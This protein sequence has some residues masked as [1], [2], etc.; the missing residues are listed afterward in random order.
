MSVQGDSAV[1]CDI[2]LQK[3][4]LNTSL[5]GGSAILTFGLWSSKVHQASQDTSGLGTFSIT[6]MQGNKTTK[7]LLLQPTLLYKEA[8]T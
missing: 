6:T 2:G 1:T 7:N 3:E 5:I 4:Y 8:T